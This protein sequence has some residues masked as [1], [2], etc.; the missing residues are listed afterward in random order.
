MKIGKRVLAFLLALTMVLSNLPVSALAQEL[1]EPSEPAEIVSEPTQAPEET[2]APATESSEETGAPAEEAAEAPEETN[3]LPPETTAGAVSDEPVNSSSHVPYLTVSRYVTDESGNTVLEDCGRSITLTGWPGDEFQLALYLWE[4]S[5][6]WNEYRGRKVGGEWQE[7]W[8]M[9]DDHNYVFSNSACFNMYSGGGE[10]DDVILTIRDYGYTTSLGYTYVNDAKEQHTLGLDVDTRM[11]DGAVTFHTDSSCSDDSEITRLDVCSGKE[12]VFYLRLDPEGTMSLQ[13]VSAVNGWAEC[14]AEEDKYHVWKVQ[15]TDEGLASIPNGSS[16]ELLLKLEATSVVDGETVEHSLTESIT[17]LRHDPYVSYEWL[18]HEGAYWFQQDG[19][20]GT[21]FHVRPGDINY[22]I[23]YLNTWNGT[24]Y[25]ATPTLVTSG[26]S[27][28]SL[29]SAA[30]MAPDG[31]PLAGYYYAV[32]ATRWDGTAIL[33]SQSDPDATGLDVNTGMGPGTFHSSAD[34]TSSTYL[35]N[36]TYPQVDPDAGEVSF[37]YLLQETGAFWELKSSLRVDTSSVATLEKVSDI[38]SDTYGNS[39]GGVYKITLRQ[40]Y[41]QSL[42]EAGNEQWFPVTVSYAVRSSGDTENTPVN[43]TWSHSLWCVYTPDSETPDVPDGEHPAY[44]SFGLL[45]QAEDGSFIE[46]QGENRQW[47]QFRITPQEAYNAVFYLN[48]W[49][50]TEYVSAPTAMQSNAYITY[51]PI[52]GYENYYTVTVSHW[53]QVLE[54]TTAMEDGSQVGGV[55]IYTNRHTQNWYSST[56]MSNA[57]SLVEL[58]LEPG[59]QPE[60]YVGMDNTMDAGYAPVEEPRLQGIADGLLSLEKVHDKLYKV[61][62]TQEGWNV[63]AQDGEMY[64]QLVWPG[65][66]STTGSITDDMPPIR[67]WMDTQA[68]NHGTYLSF[69]WLVDD[70]NGF[71]EDGSVSSRDQFLIRPG[72]DFCHIYYLNTWNEKTGAYESTP[73]HVQSDFSALNMEPLTDEIA[74][75]ATNSEYYYRVSGTEWEQ[76]GSVYCMVDGQKIALTVRV[77]LGEYSAHS[78]QE[79]SGETWLQTR[80]VTSTTEDYSF[81]VRFQS[82]FWILD[83]IWV[84]EEGAATITDLGSGVYKVTPSKE[85]VESIWDWNRNLDV[86]VSVHAWNDEAWTDE[87]QES[88][89]FWGEDRSP[90]LTVGWLEN[91][92]QGFFESQHHDGRDISMRKDEA[93]FHSYYLN[94]W[95]GELGDYEAQLVHVQTDSESILLEKMTEVMAGDILP[96]EPAADYFYRIS[97]AEW[98]KEASL[99]CLYEGQKVFLPVA[100]ELGEQSFH[101]GPEGTTDTFITD[102]LV[103]PNGENTLYF[104]FESTF[105]NLTDLELAEDW[106]GTVQDLGGGIYAITLSSEFVQSVLDGGQNLQVK[107]SVQAINDPGWT[108]EWYPG[109]HCWY[110]DRS[111]YLTFGWLDN[112]GEGWQEGE[113]HEGRDFSFHLGDELWHIYYLNVWNEETGGFD[114]WPV[115]VAS[116]NSNIVL[117]KA[118]EIAPGQPN[119]DYFYRVT[120]EDWDDGS[121]YCMYEGQKISLPVFVNLGEDSFHTGIPCTTGNYMNHWALDPFAQEQSIY[122][123]FQSDYW[124]IQ[125]L[126]PADFLEGTV[127]LEELGEGVYRVTV[128][129]AFAMSALYGR[130][131][132]LSLN[133]K[134]R[135]D[136]SHTEYRE[137]GIWCYGDIP[138]PEAVLNLN[139]ESYE[140]IENDKIIHSYPAGADEEGNQIWETEIV[141]SLP[142]G[143]AYDLG[144][145][146]LT[147][148]DAQGIQIST[149]YRWEDHSNGTSGTNLPNEDLTIELIGESSL[150]NDEDVALWFWGGVNVTFTGSGS[151][152]IKSINDPGNTDWDGYPRC[153]PALLANGCSLTFGGNVTVTAEVAGEGLQAHW[154][155][156]GYMGAGRGHLVAMDL[157]E[158]AVTIR[159]NAVVTTLVPGGA[160]DNGPLLG[161]NEPVFWDDRYPGGYGGMEGFRSLKIT[162]GVLNT[163]TLRIGES[164]TEEGQLIPHSYAQS[165][166]VV[167]ITGLGS[168]GYNEESQADHWHYTGLEGGESSSIQITGGQLNIDVQPTDQERASSSYFFGLLTRGGKLHIQGGEVTIQGTGGGQAIRLENNTAFTLEGGK[169]T[170]EAGDPEQFCWDMALMDLTPGSTASFLG[171]TIETQGTCLLLGGEA[172]YDGTELVGTNFAMS[173]DNNFAMHSGTITI[174]SGEIGAN[175]MVTL[176]GGQL[177]LTGTFMDVNNGFTFSGGRIEMDYRDVDPNEDGFFHPGIC[178]NTYFEMTGDAELI[179]RNQV[180]APAMEVTGH[181]Q[182]HGGV[183]DVTNAL[184]EHPAVVFLN[185]EEGQEVTTAFFKTGGQFNLRS[186]D[187]QTLHQGLWVMDRELLLLGGQLSTQDAVVRI[188]GQGLVAVNDLGQLSV[189]DGQLSIQDTGRLILEEGGQVD[190]NTAI[191]NRAEDEWYIALMA[192]WETAL[193]IHGGILNVTARDIDCAVDVCGTYL[194]TGGE[195]TINAAC[196]QGNPQGANC[197]GAALKKNFELRGGI[198]NISG[199]EALQ[200]GCAVSERGENF[201]QEIS[202]GQLNIHGES[203]GIYFESPVTIAGGD[204]N[205]YVACAFLSETLLWGQGLRVID[206]EEPERGPFVAGL[207]MTGGTLDIT[208]G[209]PLEGYEY[210]GS[211]ILCSDST[212][213]LLG[214]TVVIT[215]ASTA[216]VAEGVD[217][218]KGISFGEEQVIYSLA[219]G[220]ELIPLDYTFEIEGTTY[221]ATNFEEDNQP[222]DY[223]TMTNDQFVGSLLLVTGSCG[224]DTTWQLEEGTLKLRGAGFLNS[225]P[226]PF[227]APWAKLA[228]FITALEIGEGVNHLGGYAF[229]DLGKLSTITFLGNAPSFDEYAFAGV[230]ATAKYPADE[231]GWTSAVRQSYGGQITWAADTEEAVVTEIHAS[232][233]YLLPGLSAQLTCVISDPSQAADVQVLWTLAP[234]CEEY[235]QL[236]VDGETVTVTAKTTGR[237]QIITVLAQAEG[238]SAEPCALELP[239]YPLAEQV[240]I[241]LGDQTVSGTEVRFDYAENQTLTLAGRLGPNDIAEVLNPLVSWESADTDIATVENGVVTF[242]SYDQ[243]EITA[244]ALDGSGKSASVTLVP[245]YRCIGKLT[246]RLGETSDLLGQP[247]AD[248]LQVGDQTTMVVTASDGTEIPAH[249]LTFTVTSGDKYAE[250][251][252]D[253]VIEAT[254]PKG[255]VKVRASLTGDPENRKVTVTL[256]TIPTAPVGLRLDPHQQGE[257]IPNP[258]QEPWEGGYILADGF[259]D[260]GEEGL[261]L[262]VSAGSKKTFT[263]TAQGLHPILGEMSVRG[264]V[265]WTTSSS[266]VATVKEA[267]DGTV[268]VTIPSSAKGTCTIKAVSKVNKNVFTTFTVHIRDFAP[269]LAKSTVTINSHLKAN[270]QTIAIEE[271]MENPVVD[272]QLQVYDKAAGGYVDTDAFEALYEDGSVTITALEAM[273]KGTVKAQLALITTYGEPT[274]EALSIKVANSSPRLTVK[275]TR[276]LHTADLTGLVT[277]TAK[278]AVIEAVELVDCGYEILDP[279]ADGTYE[280]SLVGDAADVSG[281]LLVTMEGYHPVE[282][283]IKLTANTKAYTL[284]LNTYLEEASASAAVAFN[285]QVQA[286]EV[287]VYDSETKT[288]IP[289][290]DFAAEY[291]DGKLTVE[292]LVQDAF[293]GSR[294]ARVRIADVDSANACV[295]NVTIKA[296]NKAPS[297]TVKQTKKVNLLDDNSYGLLTITAGD[298]EITDISLEDKLTYYVS[299]Q[300]EDG[301]YRL[302]YDGS[303]KAVSK[304]KLTVSVAGYRVDFEKTVTIGTEKVKNKAVLGETTLRFYRSLPEMT[305]ETTLTTYFVGGEITDLDFKAPNAEGG[306]LS[307][308]CADGIVTVE[309]LDPEVL[310]KAGTYRFTAVP[311]TAEGE[312]L[313]K[314]TLT[315]KVEAAP[316]VKLKTTSAKLKLSQMG[317]AMVQIAVTAPIAQGYPL[318]FPQLEDGTYAYADEILLNYNQDTGMLEV[319]LKEGCTTTGK[320]V[321]TL[322]PLYGDVEVATV[323]LTV[324]VS[325]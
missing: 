175:G 278:D 25:T 38:Y 169:L 123:R 198:L 167:N 143:F 106:T 111:P 61:T 265:T 68:E 58:K 276:K 18:G 256:K 162:G 280:V 216:V 21:A 315:V 296:S 251:N 258:D 244:T 110:E 26:S 202:G 311:E 188:M 137:P 191:T 96:G 283:T 247:I 49:N 277:V 262:F 314:I 127:E 73:V 166:G 295:V 28:V 180:Q 126:E 46:P 89:W 128:G 307:V 316:K 281:T 270:S 273:D 269:E 217:P 174:T 301:S 79:F 7:S 82:D 154:D 53:D 12:N 103:D 116:D 257:V 95:N 201:V 94:I 317:E 172:I 32:T 245:Y 129:E 181:L 263:L 48:T 99:Y 308:S 203:V 22:Q 85:F 132:V 91:N 226:E 232:R 287:S 105:W 219:S 146:K 255:T 45:D 77:G 190:I 159:D 104:R 118:A 325:K 8:V 238:S 187:G 139:G 239:L 20:R 209:G 134:A 237:K 199:R 14:T 41:I 1:T 51:A 284:T 35:S 70:G 304:G 192:D 204:V 90:F 168:Y 224:Q 64:P 189:K 268:T 254:A 302:C 150:V 108:E 101:S 34:C 148:H 313:A 131:V 135:D 29:S 107:I 145:N 153:F 92:G 197:L 39:Y 221:Y 37:Y 193:E 149:C 240:E 140:F 183:I 24:G 59:V 10:T 182:Q 156:N 151:L 320:R 87:F 115:H 30:D 164:W 102:F 253:G 230:T 158:S 205:V 248:G 303:E 155:E 55:T 282:K 133:L 165:G 33:Y 266:R 152:H 170:V 120:A 100:V 109:I 75:G 293:T 142:E 275:Q 113:L 31:D 160:R 117:E 214:G 218:E 9:E 57:T 323:K 93:F 136:P 69:G 17:L 36:V 177:I 52:D 242:H 207:T 227:S 74:P 15:V 81:Y 184:T 65:Q 274:V 305:A 176:D 83:D 88:V 80:E 62:L 267:A 241:L 200:L 185:N 233:A 261:H 98:D 66:W 86:K 229:Q 163:T 259:I 50:G 212:V 5:E 54:L 147:L 114:A 291:A 288:Y 234:G 211:G 171:G 178:I 141:D 4:W 27:A 322:T 122:F 6:T 194:Q 47:R 252:A 208:L 215:G 290:D 138:A 42:V 196:T 43:E 264:Q 294:K 2:E 210:F 318:S 319:S 249:M 246:G 161:E 272:V 312:T 23:F 60:L 40:D 299:G 144:E 206:W 173:I 56:T 124:E 225:Y 298:A 297:I 44:L 11:P 186:L 97:A 260:Y 195:V 125:S 112:F 119:G 222:G 63:L 19:S 121:I 67:L 324:T 231:S 286:E 310:P 292:Y 309:A 71:Y 78:S 157:N 250:V 279:A 235:A 76:Q 243:V 72:R 220:R 289:S 84:A 16:G 306:K 285:P 13:S 130:D 3:E 300:E 213:R 228:E 179:I 271:H 236:T 321:I 223:L